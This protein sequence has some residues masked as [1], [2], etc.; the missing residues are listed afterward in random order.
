[1]TVTPFHNYN[2]PAIAFDL[3]RKLQ[4]VL[5][6]GR[7]AG[8]GSITDQ[9]TTTNDINIAVSNAVDGYTDISS[10]ASLTTNS[11]KVITP[12]GAIL[13]VNDPQ[14]EVLSIAKTSGNPRI[15]LIVMEHEW[16]E[17]V[18]GQAAT[19]SVIQGTAA[20]TPLA[21]TPTSTYQTIIGQ[22]YVS[23]NATS[24]ADLTYTKAG[25]PLPGIGTPDYNQLLNELL[26]I[27][28]QLEV[29][30]VKGMGNLGAA[31]PP[32]LATKIGNLDSHVSL[33]QAE[34][35]ILKN[36]WGQVLIQGRIQISG[37]V[38]VD[39]TFATLT[40]DF[41]AWPA[42]GQTVIPFRLKY[43]TTATEPQHGIILAN[44]DWQMKENGLSSGTYNVEPI[45]YQSV[46]TTLSDWT[47]AIY[48]SNNAPTYPDSPL[49]P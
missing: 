36:P 37:N 18:G 17:V 21:P 6:A 10:V 49:T 48:N 12:Q 2:S 38:A 35:Q 15:D 25:T 34:F 31:T 22:V 42:S 44:G 30:A 45:F 4:G 40:P 16:Q 23:A 43:G 7:Y 1:M 3:L 14:T 28:E 27:D 5:R 46:N 47:R 24:F 26:Y 8:F 9:G 33:N 19:L 13:L 20:A 32:G 41:R 39:T 11:G 29:S